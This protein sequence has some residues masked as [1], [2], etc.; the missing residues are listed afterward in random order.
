MESKQYILREIVS[1]AELEIFLKLRYHC[2]CNSPSTLFVDKNKNGI[3]VNYYDRNS[4]HYGIY[5][6]LQ[7]KA[8][9]VGYFRIVLEKP[10]AADVWVDNILH[11]AGL[12]GT[13]NRKPRSIFPCLAIYPDSNLEKQFYTQ[14]KGSDKTGKI[15]RL[16]IVKG[17]RSVKLSLQII[18][19]AFAISLLYLHQAFVGCFQPHSKAYIKFGFKQYPG[20]SAFSIDTKLE[21]NEGVILF[22]ETNYI[23]AEFKTQFKIMQDQF[24]SYKCLSFNA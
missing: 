22:C 15:S 17:E 12:T 9:P 13:I 20:T 23:S 1:E 19:S 18:R 2:F 16:F 5:L 14:K 6:R 7:K 3:D 21:R 11:K 8:V 4:L 10:T 24:L